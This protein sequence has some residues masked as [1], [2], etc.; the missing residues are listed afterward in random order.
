MKVSSTTFLSGAL[1]QV[2]V[3]TGSVAF[4]IKI[5]SSKRRFL[6]FGGPLSEVVLVTGYDKRPAR[7]AVPSN[8]DTQEKNEKFNLQI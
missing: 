2:V 8:S 1:T 4:D 3:E 6:I 7:D 5:F